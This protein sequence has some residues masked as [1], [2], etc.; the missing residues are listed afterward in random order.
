MPAGGSFG[1]QGLGSDPNAS[2]W[3]GAAG[4]KLK[5]WINPQAP[6]TGGGAPDPGSGNAYK[7]VPNASQPSPYG[8][9]SGPGILESWFNQR[10]TGTD[11]AFE[12]AS[13]RGMDALGTRYGAAGMGNSGAARQGESDFM[14]NL[15]GQ[16]MGQ[17][18]SLAGG[19]SG[20]HMGRLGMMFNQGL[21]LAGGQAGLASAYDL[22]AAGNM[23]AANAAQ[24]QM[25]LNSAAQQ[26]NAR[27]GYVSNLMTG[28][29]LIAGARGRGGGSTNPYDP[30]ALM[31]PNF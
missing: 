16:R 6:K 25:F 13:K 17:L 11:P 23:Q 26:Q 8:S 20:E 1:L 19:A 9:Q 24:Q 7:N 12:Y 21:G 5:N 2:G 14:A 31:A 15:V 27:Q 28:G 4:V 18:D 29:G 22:G 10:A 30:D 3:R